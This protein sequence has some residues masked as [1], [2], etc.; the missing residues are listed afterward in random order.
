MQYIAHTLNDNHLLFSHTVLLSGEVT[1][2]LGFLRE[3]TQ[4]FSLHLLQYP[5]AWN[6]KAAL[7]ML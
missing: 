7:A 6:Q 5:H 4:R 1:Y 3:N 2:I